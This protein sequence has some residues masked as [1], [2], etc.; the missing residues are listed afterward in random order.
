MYEVH[1]VLNCETFSFQIKITFTTFIYFCGFFGSFIFHTMRR[2]AFLRKLSFFSDCV[3]QSN[4]QTRRFASSLQ[5]VQLVTKAFLVD[6]AKNFG[7]ES[8]EK[9]CEKSRSD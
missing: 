4:E 7:K 5:N 1:V 3:W 2:D 8:R 6:F 9:P